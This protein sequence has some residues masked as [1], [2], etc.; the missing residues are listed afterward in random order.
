MLAMDEA[1]FPPPTPASA[2]RN[3]RV[4]KLVYPVKIL[5]LAAVGCRA[6]RRI[7]SAT[8]GTSSSPAE[9]IV[10][11]RPPNFATAKV[12]GSRSTEPQAAGIVTSRN[13]SAATV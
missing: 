8:V 9:T 5:G 7:A 10:Q 3:S 1:K 11:F 6:V 13:L 12:Y 2:P 4:W